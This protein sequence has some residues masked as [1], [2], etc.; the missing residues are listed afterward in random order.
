METLPLIAANADDAIA[1]GEGLGLQHANWARAVLNNGLGRYPDAWTAAE[2]A[3]EEDYTPFITACA[4]PEL[5]EAAVRSGQT[6]VATDALCRLSTRTE[7]S[8]KCSDWAAGIWARSQALLSRGEIAERCY[9]EAIERL[10][11]TPLRPDLAR[12]HL[13]Y[14][15]WLRRQARRVDARHQLRAAYDL[16]TAMGAEAFAERTRSE[17]QAAGEKVRNAKLDTHTMLTPQEQ[18]IARL[19]SKRPHQRRNRRGI[20]P[21]RPDRRMAPP[22]DL[23]QARD[24]LAKG[25]H[26]GAAPGRAPA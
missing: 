21:Q 13:L 4:L 19:G 2:Q 18:H 11:R 22:Q 26:R 12:A 14:G 1:R 20:V 17:L 5:I 3:A 24:H 8:A 16:F 10:G 6:V 7:N 25:T 23:H 15:E 9:V